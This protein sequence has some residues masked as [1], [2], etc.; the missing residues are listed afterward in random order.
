MLL[1]VLCLNMPALAV[2]AALETPAASWLGPPQALRRGL[3]TLSHTPQ[4][5]QLSVSRLGLQVDEPVE[6]TLTQRPGVR[7][8]AAAPLHWIW[9]TGAPARSAGAYFRSPAFARLTP[10][11]QAGADAAWR[12]EAQP[13]GA[14]TGLWLRL[15]HP[16]LNTALDSREAAALGFWL[17]AEA[18]AGKLRVRL[19][20]AAGEAGE[21]ALELG[22]LEK[23]YWGQPV[24]G[25]QAVRVPLPSTGLDRGE[26]AQLIVAAD[27]PVSFELR[28]L[29]LLGADLA[30]L[31][32]PPSPEPARAPRA[33][34]AAPERAL[35]LW[36][37]SELLEPAQRDAAFD[38]LADA[39]MT[40]VFVQL[41]GTSGLPGE[42][43]P[44]PLV[45]EG[46]LRA[47]YARGL[48]V[49]ALDGDP[50]YA[51]RA[52]HE[53]VLATQRHL[54]DYNRSQ[55]PEARFAGMQ[56]DIEPYLLP[57]YFGA[58]QQALQTG[59]L[60]LVARLAQEREQAGAGEFEMGLAVPFWLDAPDEWSGKRATLTHRGKTRLLGDHLL[61]HV[62]HL[63]LM[64]YRTRSQGPGGLLANTAELLQ[65]AADQGKQLWV[66][67]ETLPLPAEDHYTFSGAP[68]AGW[69]EPKPHAQLALVEHAQQWELYF[70]APGEKAPV[71]ETARNRPIWHW[72]LQAAG[73]TDPRD[74]SF[75]SLGR[76]RLEQEIAVLQDTLGAVAAYQGVVIH[77]LAGLR[78]LSPG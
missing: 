58:R 47:A 61:A 8:L 36:E 66:G 73:H 10:L 72:P 31:P 64:N 11:S 32:V 75:A 16:S 48:A 33:R 3:L 15:Y 45:W 21:T 35:W 37:A 78:A 69:P 25:W 49:Y 55:P 26:L 13:E 1:S 9:P 30:R 63:A 34:P 53:G 77:D 52:F 22:R 19:A 71:P 57:G 70:L 17:R 28:G 12:F 27:A 59:L 41:T 56:Y 5:P 42:I 43:K 29:A 7:R 20:D 65:R 76:G 14:P 67:L 24:A 18:G 46:L 60:D 23:F 2:G 54:L 6:T 74:L 39:G 51:E 68:K 4:G 50:R 40:R 62:D 38:T 44:D